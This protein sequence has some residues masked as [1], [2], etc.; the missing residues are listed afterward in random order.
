MKF[1]R[2]SQSE[3]Q[4]LSDDDVIAYVVLA[5]DAGDSDAVSEALGILVYGR[6]GWLTVFI[7]KRLKGNRQDAEDVAAKV[8]EN[9]ITSSFDGESV[10]QF[11]NLMKTMA[12]RRSFEFNQKAG[13]AKKD[14]AYDADDPEGRTGLP[15]NPGDSGETEVKMV[16][17]AV[18]AK[19]TPVH[20]DVVELRIQGFKS[21]EVAEMI[22]DGEHQLDKPMTDANADQIYKRFRDE[23]RRELGMAG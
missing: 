17:S 21:K 16:I 23:L 15:S 6:L 13:K 9:V 1:R 5:R 20:Q 7:G 11:V 12:V 18:M 4:A 14:V 2:K 8:M 10:G 3:T 19:M 22:N